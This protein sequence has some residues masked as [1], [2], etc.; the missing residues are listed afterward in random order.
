[1]DVQTRMLT[2]DH[3]Q[4]QVE[5]AFDLFHAYEIDGEEF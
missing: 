4:H 5:V 2:E 3:K 1:M